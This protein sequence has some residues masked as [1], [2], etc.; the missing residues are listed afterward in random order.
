MGKGKE[1]KK[2]MWI[3]DKGRGRNM[4]RI[5]AKASIILLFTLLGI[6]LLAMS[7]AIPYNA[8]VINGISYALVS[9]VMLL[10]GMTVAIRCKMDA[11]SLG[12]KGNSI[13]KR[14]RSEK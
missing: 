3:R 13:I 12:I 1:T 11:S 5:I 9:L 2:R 10:V 14:K 8:I 7:G 6:T 4:G